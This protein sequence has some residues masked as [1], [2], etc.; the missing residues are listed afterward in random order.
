MKKL[1][2]LVLATVIGFL[3]MGVT[4]PVSANPGGEAI[5][6]STEK[7][8]DV[9][10]AY[11]M[12]KEKHKAKINLAVNKNNCVGVV[13][14]SLDKNVAKVSK[15]GTITA[16]SSGICLI[17][18]TYYRGAG[19]VVIGNTYYILVTVCG[20]NDNF[21]D[22]SIDD[23]AKVF[24]TATDFIDTKNKETEAALQ[25]YAESKK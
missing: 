22:I 11:I 19:T 5:Q 25:K 2:A 20:D 7:F 17:A 6:Y 16:V 13:Y 10:E 4:I 24:E 12:L 18:V 8:T 21:F 9:L 15:K 14:E 3:T 1:I 23:Y